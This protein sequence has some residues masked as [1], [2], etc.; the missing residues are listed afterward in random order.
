MFKFIELLNNNKELIV[1]QW[2]ALYCFKAFEKKLLFC[3]IKFPLN[4]NVLL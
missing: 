2:L 1:R 3:T 4:V